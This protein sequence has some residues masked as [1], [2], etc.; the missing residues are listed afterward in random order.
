MRFSEGAAKFSTGMKNLTDRGLA[1]LGDAGCGATLQFLSL[2]GLHTVSDAGIASLGLPGNAPALTS[3]SLDRMDLVTDVGLLSLSS[4]GTPLA[5]LLL[6]NVCRLTLDGV[7]EF[8]ARRSCL[9]DLQVTLG[10]GMFKREPDHCV[11]RGASPVQL[12]ASHMA[13]FFAMG[14]DNSVSALHSLRC[15]VLSPVLRLLH[16]L[17][18][19]NTE[20]KLLQFL[21]EDVWKLV[22]GYCE[23]SVYRDLV[24]DLGGGVSREFYHLAKNSLVVQRL[25]HPPTLLCGLVWMQSRESHCVLTK[26]MEVLCPVTAQQVAR[27]CACPGFHRL[28]HLQVTVRRTG[29][30]D[31]PWRLWTMD[32]LMRGLVELGL[33]NVAVTVQQG[34]GPRAQ[35]VVFRKH[36]R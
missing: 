36:G 7:G 3:L 22:L 16:Q 13:A 14:T 17:P 15:H 35:R 33:G 5:Y 20:G 4:M 19:H 21:P 30:R 10:S 8:L 1:E 34:N 24:V 29:G 23:R 32:S 25:H 6:Q 26:S 27:L 12:L 9:P 2:L 28:S 31:D 11:F 18:G